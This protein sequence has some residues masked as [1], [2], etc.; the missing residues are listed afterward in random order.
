[1]D[2]FLRVAQM[3]MPLLMSAVNISL[4]ILI[5]MVLITVT[6][7]AAIVAGMLHGGRGR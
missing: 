5:A 3:T 7:V 2:K 6:V 4:R 1:L